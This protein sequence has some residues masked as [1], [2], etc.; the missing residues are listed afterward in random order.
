ME[1]G[2]K[3]IEGLTFTKLVKVQ[4]WYPLKLFFSSDALGF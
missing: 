3:K 4:D 1:G 2:V